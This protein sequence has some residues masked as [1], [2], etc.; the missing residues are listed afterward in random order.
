ME[1]EGDWNR[2]QWGYYELLNK[3]VLGQLALYMEKDRVRI[4]LY[5]KR[6][7]KFQMDCGNLNVKNKL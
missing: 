2:L 5:S 3:L 4:L 7:N 1:L 6:R